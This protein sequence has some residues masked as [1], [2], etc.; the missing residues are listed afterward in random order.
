MQ[1]VG[2]LPLAQLFE[3][4]RRYLLYFYKHFDLSKAEKFIEQCLQCRGL[5][6]FTG[7][8]KSGII[9]EKIVMTLISTGTRALYLPAMNV[10]HGDIGVVSDDDLVV[11]LSKSGETQELVEL[12][13]Y[14]HRRGARVLLVS[15]QEGGQLAKMADLS[16]CLPTEKELCPFDLAPT[17]SAA[18]QLLFGDL[19]AM[20]LMREKGF[21]LDE[22]AKNHPSGAI[23]KKI[24]RRVKDLMKTGDQLPL[25][26][27]EDRLMDVIVDL[28]DKK[29]GCLIV[30]SNEGKLLGLFTDG[31]LR[32]ALQKK[33]AQ[34]MEDTMETLMNPSPIT[35]TPDYLALSAAKKMQSQRYVMAAPVLAQDK[36]V[37]LI[38]MH[39]I[40]NTGIS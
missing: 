37:G 20:A 34:I 14:I 38:R 6:I 11:M 10:L 32:R 23:G 9:A 4:Q 19:L 1:Y 8:G 12:V 18:L 39:D 15:S 28:S 36:V 5:L 26:R 21:Q 17:T 29:C 16:V 27:K 2:T 7:V 40:V 24:T 13:P 35:V 22:Y 30:I 25:C 33:G 31:D 3:E